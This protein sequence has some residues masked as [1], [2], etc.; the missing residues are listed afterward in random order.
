MCPIHLVGWQ[1]MSQ[2]IQKEKSRKKEGGTGLDDL[3]SILYQE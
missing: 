3:I 2:F 1:S